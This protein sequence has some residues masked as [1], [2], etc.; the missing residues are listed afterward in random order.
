MVND[1]S[2][3]LIH[4][5][6]RDGGTGMTNLKLQKLLYYVQGFHVALNG[7]VLFEDVLEALPT[8]PVIRKVYTTYARYGY[9]AIDRCEGRDGSCLTADE[10]NL[11]K[12]VWG[13]FASYEAVD[14]ELLIQSEDP[15]K[16]AREGLGTYDGSFRVIDVNILGDY[17][18]S[19]Y[20]FR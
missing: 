3:Y 5:S 6:Y 17:I 20:T 7:S 2:G 14:L 19:E 4:L 11:I 15:W 13:I 8:G 1:V 9:S 10:R 12:D 16:L 18:R